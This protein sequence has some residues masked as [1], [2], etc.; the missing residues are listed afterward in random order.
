MKKIF[1][2]LL[3]CIGAS[4]FCMEDD[5]LLGW[6]NEGALGMINHSRYLI[7][8]KERGDSLDDC[9]QLSYAISGINAHASVDKKYAGL[10][11]LWDQKNSELNIIYAL[12][13]TA[14]NRLVACVACFIKAEKK[15]CVFHLVAIDPDYCQTNVLE[16]LVDFIPMIT[17]GIQ[18]AMA[19]VTRDLKDKG[20]VKR[21]EVLL[22]KAGFKKVD[23]NPASCEDCY[24]KILKK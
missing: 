16:E 15:L 21:A 12:D 13:Q 4:G 23:S 6:Q 18:K 2:T 7:G 11:I 5:D 8:I 14:K 9:K 3:L 24:E 19:C 1:L 10:E 20:A 22:S 17:G